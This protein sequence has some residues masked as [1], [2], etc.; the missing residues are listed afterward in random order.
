LSV[1]LRLLRCSSV[2]WFMLPH[3]PHAITPATT[4]IILDAEL[5][6]MTEEAAGRPYASPGT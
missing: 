5:P 3:A 2:N 1:M 4:I 6:E